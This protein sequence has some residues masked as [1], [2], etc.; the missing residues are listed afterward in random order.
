MPPNASAHSVI[1]GDGGAIQEHQ[2]GEPLSHVALLPA[3]CHAR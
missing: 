1:R 2:F 3:D